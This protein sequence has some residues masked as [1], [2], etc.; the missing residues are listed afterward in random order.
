M[1]PCLMNVTKEKI[2]EMYIIK[3]VR[4]LGWRFQ[5]ASRKEVKSFV[6]NQNDLNALISIANYVEHIQK[7]QY[8]D[9][10]LFAKLYIYLYMKIL[11]NDGS[12]IED[13][14]A[15]RKIYNLLKKPLSQIIE[16]FQKS[17]NESGQYAILNEITGRGENHLAI[18][19]KAEKEANFQKL[20][21]LL[22]DPENR[23]KFFG[24]IWDYDKVQKLAEAE[25][26][27]AINYFK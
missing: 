16:D 4:R 17:L 6:I 18:Q 23:I 12:T 20:E 27:Q 25:V 13:G 9:H 11:V 24:D 7:Q 5:E 10:Q 3:A 8:Q 26:N 19:T 22:K 1:K 15:R 21:E 14:F 2:G